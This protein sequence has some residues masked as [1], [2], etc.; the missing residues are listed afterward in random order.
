MVILWSFKMCK[1]ELLYVL[2]FFFGGTLSQSYLFIPPWVTT[3]QRSRYR[4]S[5]SKET[6]VSYSPS[7]RSCSVRVGIP[8]FSLWRQRDPELHLVLRRGLSA[9]PPTFSER[10]RYT[11]SVSTHGRVQIRF[12][13][14]HQMAQLSIYLHRGRSRT[15]RKKVLVLLTRNLSGCHGTTRVVIFHSACVYPSG[16]I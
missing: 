10:S 12:L 2:F 14:V 4:C 9:G 3:P 15:R 16:F 5:N 1:L 8:S 11:G 6:Q 7:L 13:G